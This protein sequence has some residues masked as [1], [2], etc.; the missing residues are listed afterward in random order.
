LKQL[1]IEKHIPCRLPVQKLEKITYLVLLGEGF[2]KHHFVQLTVTDDSEIA[3]L[4]FKY[5]GKKSLTDVLTFPAENTLTPLLGDIV[6]DIQQAERQIG[7]SNLTTEIAT[8][9]LHGLLHLL[10]YDHIRSEDR[11]L[12]DSKFDYYWSLN[13]E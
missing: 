5:R 7:T 13:K 1:I 6:I 12:M 10:H 3:A 11:L 2:T 8:L 4:N 9:F